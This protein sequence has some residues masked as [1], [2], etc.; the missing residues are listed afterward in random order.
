MQDTLANAHIIKHV[1][2]FIPD[3]K[4][5]STKQLNTNLITNPLHKKNHQTLHNLLPI[6]I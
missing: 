4:F 5:F 3:K 2:L 6:N 1:K